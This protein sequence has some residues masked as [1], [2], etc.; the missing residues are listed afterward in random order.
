MIRMVV[1]IERDMGL[2]KNLA[3][4]R[5]KRAIEELRDG[6]M[7]A[8][9]RMLGWDFFERLMAAYALTCG[10]LTPP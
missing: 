6:E 9:N 7:V 3:R 1:K 2:P 10:V 8:R 4:K 5:D